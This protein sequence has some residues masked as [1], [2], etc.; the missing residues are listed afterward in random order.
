[1]SAFESTTQDSTAELTDFDG[2]PDGCSCL[3]SF[4]GLPCWACY[5]AGFERPNPNAEGDD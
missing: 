2:R 3:P 5:R 4:E 1:M